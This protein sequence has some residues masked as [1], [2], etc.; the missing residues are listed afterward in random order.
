M[1]KGLPLYYLSTSL[2]VFLDFSSLL[3]SSALLWLVIDHLPFVLPV[4]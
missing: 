2:A 1:Y 3:Y 4:K